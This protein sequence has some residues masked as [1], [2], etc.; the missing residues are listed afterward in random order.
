MAEKTSTLTKK[1]FTPGPTEV[2]QSVYDEIIK[3][4]IYHRSSE[5]KKLYSELAEKLKTIFFTKE[6]LFVLTTSGTGTMEAAVLN[7]CKPDDKVLYINQGRFGKRW[8]DMC[9]AHNLETFEL[10]VEAGSA[11]TIDEL[12][13]IDLDR[14]NLILLTHSETSTATVTDVKKLTKYIK[15]NSNALVVVD[16]ITSIGALEFK[17]DDWHVDIAV[18]ASQKAFMTPPGLGIIAFNEQAKEKMYDNNMPRYYFDLRKEIKSFDETGY[19]AWTPAIGLFAGL[20]K[21]CDIILEEGIGDCWDRVSNIADY[22]RKRT[23]EMGFNLFS[24]TPSDSLTALTLPN[25]LSSDLM[26][27]VLKQKYG[28]TVA[29]GQAELKG[30]IFRV[31]HM[32]NFIKQDFEL[33]CDIIE[34]EIKLI[35]K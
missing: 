7:F 9:I 30:K 27:K 25:D 29:N 24:L 2:P 32:G 12:K 26:V 5:F 6:N 21:A 31:S 1:I 23:Q 33:F 18:S 35:V 16:G 3:H 17:M 34:K 14:F 22:Y 4:K 13:E 11:A 19:P 28:I 8:G 15:E 20:N 10:S